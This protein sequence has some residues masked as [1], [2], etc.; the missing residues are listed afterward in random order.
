[1]NSSSLIVK[2]LL[3]LIGC[4]AGAYVGDD[5][6]G[7]GALGWA[8]GGVIVAGCVAPLFQTLLSWREDSRRQG[9]AD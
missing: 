9:S 3:A 6:L 4:I 5:L 8:I 2:V 1:M 7:G